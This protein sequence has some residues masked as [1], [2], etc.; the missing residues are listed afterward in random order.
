MIFRWR[1]I[2]SYLL[3]SY[4]IYGVL[5]LLKWAGRASYSWQYTKLKTK[6]WYLI[7]ITI[8]IYLS[9]DLT[10]HRPN[11]DSVIVPWFP[12]YQIN[13]F[14]YSVLKV[15]HLDHSLSFW[16]SSWIEYS[17]DSCQS[18]QMVKIPPCMVFEV[19]FLIDDCLLEKEGRRKEKNALLVV[20]VRC[21]TWFS[22]LVYHPNCQPFIW[23]VRTSY[24]YTVGFWLLLILCPKQH[25]P[26]SF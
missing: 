3:N 23:M 25:N 6:F 26:S 17:W 10:E 5:A 24:H 13:K 4:E 19:S 14:L 12:H 22:F 18:I 11:I 20:V 15:A 1:N 2:H 21:I 7:S 16:N 9:A 8:E